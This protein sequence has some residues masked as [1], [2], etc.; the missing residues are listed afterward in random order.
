VDQVVEVLFDQ[1]RPVYLWRSD[2]GW[3]Q[4]LTRS[5]ARHFGISSVDFQS[6]VSENTLI[7]L[8]PDE[9]EAASIGVS[10]LI[11][12]T[13]NGVPPLGAFEEWYFQEIRDRSPS[14]SFDD[15]RVSRD[16]E[17]EL[18][19]TLISFYSYLLSLDQALIDARDE[20]KLFFW[21]ALPM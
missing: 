7:H 3:L 2:G 6:P 18:G 15:A 21:C 10:A 1:E 16:G 13:E 17:V 12:R 8:D 4:C 9:M 14:S 11:Q 5:C 19:E 20:G